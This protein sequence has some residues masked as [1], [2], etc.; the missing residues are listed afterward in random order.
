MFEEGDFIEIPLSDG[1]SAI[2]W[3]VLL[4][5]RFKDTV[6]F[7]VFGIKGQVRNED[8]RA[9]PRLDVLGPYYTHV[10][11]LSDFGCTRV[12]YAPIPASQE[13]IT[14]RRVGGSVYVRDDYLGSVEELGA[15]DLGPMLFMGMKLI[16]NEI[17]K[18]F[19][20]T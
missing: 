18:A 10:A 14:M 1:R 19:I 5:N 4:S 9:N 6:G 12:D 16:I 8:I 15:H 2:G 7:V 20:S 3:I 13:Q 11:N 17:E